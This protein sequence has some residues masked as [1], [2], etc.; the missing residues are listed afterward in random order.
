MLWVGH[1]IQRGG[2]LGQQLD[3]DGHITLKQ[4]LLTYYL[5]DAMLRRQ[6]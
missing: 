3:A 5:R 6:R 2:A 4:G 1:V